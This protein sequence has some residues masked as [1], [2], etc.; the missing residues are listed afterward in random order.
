MKARRAESRAGFDRNLKRY[1]R[2]AV[3]VM[4]RIF[5]WK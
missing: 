5:P 3:S 4:G 1:A 2:K